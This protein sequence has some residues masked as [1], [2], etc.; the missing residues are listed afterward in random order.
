M[1]RRC[2]LA[3]FSGRR[4]SYTLTGRSSCRTLRATSVAALS[5]SAIAAT[6]A[7]TSCSER[8]RSTIAAPRS[9]DDEVGEVDAEDALF[10]EGL[11][12][13]GLQ[14]VAEP[15]LAVGRHQLGG[16]LGAEQGDDLVLH[17]GGLV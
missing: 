17:D 6:R 9:L 10:A 15:L 12:E 14:L 8:G 16:G 5:S 1:A 3:N 13:A 4:K 2:S 7:A 11:V